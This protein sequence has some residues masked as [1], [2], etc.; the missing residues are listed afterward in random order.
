VAAFGLISLVAMPGQHYTVGL[1][2]WTFAAWF[3]LG[4]SDDERRAAAPRREWIGWAATWAIALAFTA[5][6]AAA[7]RGDLRPPFRAAR[8][9]LDY[10]Y[11]FTGDAEGQA[12]TA[13]KAVTVLK[14]ESGWLKLTYWVEHPDAAQRPVQ[15]DIWRDRE[16]VVNRRLWRNMRFT[17]YIPVTA[18][19]RFVLETR[20]DRGFVVQDTAGS[21][22]RGLSL[23]LE[24]VEK[25]E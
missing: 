10:S 7:A 22:E 16:R 24:F 2:F 8:F 20:V 1:T 18:G 13:R 12:W 5:L 3:I 4:S 14:A 17:D 11:G 23:R 9:D 19:K 21:G 25:P 6:T 15:V